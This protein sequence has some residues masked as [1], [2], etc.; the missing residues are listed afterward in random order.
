MSTF[1]L[2]VGPV[3]SNDPESYADGSLTASRA[4]LARQVKVMTQAKRDMLVLQVGG[5]PWG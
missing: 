2:V 5:W 3:W 1:D 4:S